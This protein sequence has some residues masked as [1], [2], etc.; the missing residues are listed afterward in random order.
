MLATTLALLLVSLTGSDALQ[1][2]GQGLMSKLNTRTETQ[3]GPSCTANIE[4]FK[5]YKD[6]DL[7]IANGRNPWTDPFAHKCNNMSSNNKCMFE[8]G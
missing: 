1:V 7:D 6:F 5:K 8:P 2:Q 3:Q 4:R